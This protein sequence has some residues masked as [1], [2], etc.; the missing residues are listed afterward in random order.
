M[1]SIVNIVFFKK[2]S[3]LL[4]VKPLSLPPTVIWNIVESMFDSITLDKMESTILLGWQS[5]G[6]VVPSPFHHREQQCLV[7]ACWT[8]TLTSLWPA[9]EPLGCAGN[10]AWHLF[11]F[12][13]KA[14]PQCG[15]SLYSVSLWPPC[16]TLLLNHLWSWWGPQIQL[17]WPFKYHLW[18]NPS[19]APGSFSTC[20]CSYARVVESV[21]WSSHSA[22]DWLT[23]ETARGQNIPRKWVYPQHKRKIG[24]FFFFFLLL[25]CHFGLENKR[26]FL[27]CLKM[28]SRNSIKTNQRTKSN[29]TYLSC[30]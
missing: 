29:R 14:C 5:S 19:S 2:R 21:L 16:H 18:L 1:Q 23:D 9:Y 11:F 6:H 13:Q 12:L 26:Q 30:K 27:M 3:T 20:Q 7:G 15:T 10:I 24:N 17:W 8:S 4:K 22:T 28:M 25:F